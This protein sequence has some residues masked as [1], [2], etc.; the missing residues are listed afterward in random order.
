MLG[1]VAPSSVI[2]EILGEAEWTLCQNFSAASQRDAS[3]SSGKSGGYWRGA[4][5]RLL[6]DN[7]VDGELA[8]GGVNSARY[9]EILVYMNLESTSY[10]QVICEGLKLYSHLHAVHCAWE[11]ST[12]S[13]Q[14]VSERSSSSAPL[15][16][17]PADV[18]LLGLGDMLNI[19]SF[20]SGRG[21]DVQ[22]KCFPVAH[23][24][25]DELEIGNRVF[26]LG[27]LSS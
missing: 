6:L 19:G 18:S 7:Q 26:H 1:R 24:G 9:T 17:P 10:W 3:Y 11:G 8:F 20:F 21:L 16:E 13:I 25:R 22:F 15:G 4:R 23:I 27:Q 12:T 5:L 2:R 14:G